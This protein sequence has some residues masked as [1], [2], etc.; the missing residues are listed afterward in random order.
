[1]RLGSDLGLPGV[2]WSDADLDG[3]VVGGPLHEVLTGSAGLHV[4]LGDVPL[5][6]LA[7]AGGQ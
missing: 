4:N 1:M 7:A 6:S 5:V 3:A 2:L